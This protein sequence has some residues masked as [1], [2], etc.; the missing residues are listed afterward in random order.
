MPRILTNADDRTVSHPGVYDSMHA[1]SD[2][3]NS[4]TETFP[5]GE[6]HL[7]QPWRVPRDLR[8]GIVRMRPIGYDFRV[9]GQPGHRAST[10]EDLDQVVLTSG[11]PD[12]TV[13][14]QILNGLRL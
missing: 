5:I 11:L 2:N 12:N 7:S 6:K 3:V 9:L 13:L 1:L 10:Q 14:S 8:P 4:N